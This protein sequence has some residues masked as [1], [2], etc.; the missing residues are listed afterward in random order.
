MELPTVSATSPDGPS[1]HDPTVA[2][3]SPVGSPVTPR[4]RSGIEAQHNRA[5]VPEDDPM[6][7]P[8]VPGPAD[9]PT[10]G[11][12]EISDPPRPDQ[13]DGPT[14]TP[15]VT[16]E[17]DP[18]HRFGRE[19][20]VG[21]GVLVF[22]AIMGLPLGALWSVVTPRV[23]LVH[24][25]GGWAFTEE[26][27]EQYMAAD[28]IF[29]IGGLVL[30]VVA[31]VIVWLTLRRWRGPILL[32]GLVLGAIACQ[33][34][35]WQFGR[36]GRDA[37]QAS[38]DSVPIGWRIRRV[39]ELLMIDFDPSAAIDSLA[40]GHLADAAGHLALGVLATMAFGAAFTYTV[41]AGWSKHAGLRP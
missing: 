5:P 20:L 13:P 1:P 30:G 9:H 24:V 29:T 33:T 35:A 6:A 25:P 16:T 39:P 2:A 4:Q 27:P 31:A 11:A 21:L 28:G 32:A 14:P 34:A 3:P 19:L 41:C 7:T 23:E 10:T 18:G 38:L 8:A 12:T 22:M 26:N 40:A 37:Y 36:I 17:P 15:P